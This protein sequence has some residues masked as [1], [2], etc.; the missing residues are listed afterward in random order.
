MALSHNIVALKKKKT[1]YERGRGIFYLSI[2]L[3]KRLK[4]EIKFM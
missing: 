1:K 4:F 3:L 2:Y